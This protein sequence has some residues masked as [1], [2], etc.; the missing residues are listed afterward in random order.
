MIRAALRHPH[1]VAVGSLALLLLGGTAATLIP[2]D[3]LPRFRTPAVQI[4]TFYPGMPAE[5]MEKDITSR[6]ERW[7]GQ[8]NGIAR[9]ESKS[10]LGVSVVKDYFRDDVDP[11]TA[12]AQVATL[13]AADLFYLPPGTIPPMVMPFDPTASTPL[14]LLSVSSPTF[15]EAALYD[16][17]YF[18]LRNRLQGITGV[19]APAVYGGKLRR[20]LAYLDPERLHARDLSLL[21]VQQGLK[22]SNVFLPTG[23]A[24]IGDLDYQ[25]VSNAMPERAREL[26]G[27]PIAAGGDGTPI[28]LR[29][30]GQVEDGAAI[31]TNLVRVDG[32]RQVYIPIYRQPGANTLEVVGEVRRNKDAILSRLPPGIELDVVFDQSVY[33]RDAIGSVVLECAGGA[34][35]AALAI[36]VFL[37]SLRSTWIA[38]L[39]IP[40]SLLL[41]LLGLYATG[42]TLNLMT[43]GGFALAIGRLVDDSIVVI[44]NTH[45]HLALHKPPLQAALD[46]AREVAMPVLAATVTTVIVF[47]PIVFL[48]GMGRYLFTPLALAITFAI[49]ASCLIALSVVPVLAARALR[50][51]AA[52]APGRV[53]ASYGGLLAQALRH[54]L[55]VLALAAGSVA[56]A[57][58]LA[59]GIG[60]ELFPVADGGQLTVFVRAPSGTRLERSEAIVA[61][62]EEHVRAELGSD[63]R[64]LISNVGVLMD[65]P[66]AY[67]PNSGPMDAFVLVQLADGRQ[68]GAPE[69]ARH[70]RRSLPA[71]VPQAEFAFSA[72]GAVTAAL[73]GGLASPIDVQIEGNRLDVAREIALEAGRRIQA[74]P[75]AADVRIQQ[76]LDYPQ[77]FLDV[78]RDRA[79]ACRVTPQDVLRN[80]AAALSSSVSFDPAFWIDPGNGNHY[81]LGVQYDEARIGSLDAILDVP[82]TSARQRQPV[83]LRAV[84]SLRRT[85]APAEVHH[86]NI[87]RV[88]DVLVNVEDRD[89]GSV[90]TDVERE[91]AGMQLPAGYRAHVR[92]ELQNLRESFGGLGFGLLLAV[93]LVYLVL[94]LQFRSFVDPLVILAAVPLGAIG[95]VVALRATGTYFSVPAFLGLVFMVG[96]AVS[97]SILLVEFTNRLR[98]QGTPLDEAVLLGARTRLRPVLMT[99][100]ASIAGLLPLAL[101]A[102]AGAEASAP[103]ARAVI[104]GLLASTVL[105]LVVVPVLYR[106]LCGRPIAAEVELE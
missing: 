8:A 65:W 84:A 83:P 36:L 90:A 67:T 95:V 35:L 46:A 3:L 106:I 62:V 70:L 103:L 58:L 79:A 89:V 49:G 78:D 33:V 94:V 34:L 63:L 104:G 42:Q 2:A 81:F 88:T 37:R 26:G 32:R 68:R 1:A 57:G 56:G 51:H 27:F 30:V 91:L 55:A 10:M 97:N 69:W 54:K 100:L 12:M 13:A 66:A 14:C 6:L 16:I 24:R 99:S 22:A 19:I 64:R 76:K 85:T 47:L 74:I 48:T 61:Q 20:I 15:D 25:V 21:D 7:T 9:Q 50:P 59:R 23:S 92:G 86:H 11:N 53:A 41:G 43:L 75:G 98:R 71:A 5:V 31:Q 72:G 18:D 38:A 44:E 45:R 28:L 29:D 105:T 87:N 60:Y 77:L 101:G 80:V 82:V 93:A 96:I 52:A 73:N 4:V 40:L 102:G 17:A 39:A